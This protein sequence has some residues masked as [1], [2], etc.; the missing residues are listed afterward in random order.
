MPPPNSRRI[1]NKLKLCAAGA[2][3]ARG[4][5]N[6]PPFGNDFTRDFPQ[7]ARAAGIS[8]LVFAQTPRGLDRLWGSIGENGGK[9]FPIARGDRPKERRAPSPV[10]LM[11]R[12]A[13]SPV[14]RGR[15]RAPDPPSSPGPSA[16]PGP[17][18][19]PGVLPQPGFHRGRRPEKGL[20]GALIADRDPLAASDR[21]QYGG[22]PV[23]H[24]QRG[25]GRRQGR[26]S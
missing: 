4:G 20:L 17:P 3:K 25:F 2:A 1:Q 14:K 23:V 13:P 11:E 9:R 7:L 6:F 24:R 15:A 19:S 16:S 22:G 12:R 8:P 21:L 18:A 26:R 10:K 5:A